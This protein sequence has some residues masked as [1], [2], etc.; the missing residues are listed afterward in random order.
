MAKRLLTLQF[1]SKKLL[2]RLLTCLGRSFLRIFSWFLTMS[3]K[4]GTGVCE[5]GFRSQAMAESAREQTAASLR[6]LT[7]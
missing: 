3:S 7:I 2:R 6:R 5:R 1:P 4:N